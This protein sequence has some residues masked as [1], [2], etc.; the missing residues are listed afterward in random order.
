MIEKKHVSVKDVVFLTQESDME[1]PKCGCG[2]YTTRIYGMFC[3]TDGCVNCP[4]YHDKDEDQMN[5]IQVC[6]FL[7]DNRPPILCC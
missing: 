5:Q 6:S 7:S 4:P 3:L 2:F 1:N